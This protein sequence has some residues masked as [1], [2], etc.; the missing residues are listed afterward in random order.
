MSA[1][2]APESECRT[3]QLGPEHSQHIIK[4]FFDI[5]H[6]D[7]SLADEIFDPNVVLVSDRM[8]TGKGSE[9][10][11]IEGKDSMMAF[12]KQ[13]REGWKEYAFE[14]LQSISEK[15]KISIR[16]KMNGVTGENMRVKTPLKPG[17]KGIDFIVLDECSGLIKEINIA[18]ALITFFHELELS[19]V[20]V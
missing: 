4:N 19:H 15:N 10:L 12:V 1:E 18:Q 8:P 20:S 2:T 16:W 7:Y 3:K 9:P 5:W 14:L 6:G 17:S 13:C 11:R